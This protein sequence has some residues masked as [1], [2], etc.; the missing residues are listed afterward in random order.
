APLVSHA[1]PDVA[2]SSAA[3]LAAIADGQALNA[4][5]TARK[6]AGGAQRQRISEA[7]LVCADHFAERGDRAAAVKVYQEM[8]APAEAAPIRARALKS[9]ATADA[10][11]AMPAMMAELRSNTA[12]RQVPVI[13]LMST[14]PG[15]DVS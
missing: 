5:A 14:I 11:A 3:A 1:N 9:F 12:E 4:L 2:A 10:K 7:Y 8:V 15:P 6:S 13:R